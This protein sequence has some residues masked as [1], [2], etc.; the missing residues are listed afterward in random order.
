MASIR[1]CV[2]FLSLFIIVPCEPNLQKATV[3]QRET[4]RADPI[5][6]LVSCPESKVDP[7]RLSGYY[8]GRRHRVEVSAPVFIVGRDCL[9]KRA[10][11]SVAQWLGHR[12]Y[13]QLSRVRFDCQW[14]RLF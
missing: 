7:R 3:R 5:R 6:C 10:G 14:F 13:N 11:V 1:R 8:S 2:T 4:E 9:D 12:I